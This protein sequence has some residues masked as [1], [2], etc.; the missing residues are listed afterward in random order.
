MYVS[1]RSFLN[2]S[3]QT[4]I[5]SITSKAIKKDFVFLKDFRNE[6]SIDVLAETNDKLFINSLFSI[7]KFE[8]TRKLL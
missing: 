6:N 2:S 3:T 4:D 5:W 7:R 1:K 8:N